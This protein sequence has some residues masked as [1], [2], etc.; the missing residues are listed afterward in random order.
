MIFVKHKKGGENLEK[1]ALR[2]L[3]IPFLAV[4]ILLSTLHLA[5]GSFSTFYLSYDIDDFYRD[6]KGMSGSFYWSDGRTGAT[7]RF[8]IS[9]ALH[10]WS[11]N[12][13]DTPDSST[14]TIRV[15]GAAYIVTPSGAP[16]S[17]GVLR[18]R[19]EL[20]LRPIEW[21]WD[22]WPF[23]GHEVTKQDGEINIR[24]GNVGAVNLA[25]LKAGDERLRAILS[26]AASIAWGAALS[27]AGAPFIPFNPT[28]ITYLNSGADNDWKA[29]PSFADPDPDAFVEGRM[30]WQYPAWKPWCYSN[31]E[32][33]Y[34]FYYA[35]Y[36]RGFVG[37]KSYELETKI[38]VDFGYVGDTYQGTY[39]NW[40]VATREFS[41][42]WTV[43]VYWN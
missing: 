31:G 14:G 6:S 28:W 7:Y 12:H 26:I 42:R 37:Y 10:Y 23:I 3:V 13:K 18:L 16:R 30:G 29:G 36:R 5:F 20:R 22:L 32:V 40:V 17:L 33:A 38:S 1:R 39:H 19:T 27:F 25:I 11:Y 4:T 15:A 24:S 9:V 8:G 43:Y 41:D 35:Y 34:D 2:A 21:V